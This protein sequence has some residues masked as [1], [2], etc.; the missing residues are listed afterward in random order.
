MA[1][2]HAIEYSPV[3][4][5]KP[6]NCSVNYDIIECVDDALCFF[7]EE[8]TQ[9]QKKNYERKKKVCS[10]AQSKK[11]TLILR[12]SGVAWNINLSEMI[13]NLSF[14]QHLS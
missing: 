11:P 3:F 6:M 12:T 8:K 7:H 9:H 5:Y 10:F 4:W 13:T 1:K 14:P 2:I